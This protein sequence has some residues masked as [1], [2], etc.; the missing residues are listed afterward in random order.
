MCVYACVTSSSSEV[1][2]FPIGDMLAIWV[3]VA[4]RETE[5]DD[6]DAVFRGVA[7]SDQEVIRFNVAMNDSL[8][9]HLLNTLNLFE[10]INWK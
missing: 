3:P 10:T 7:P 1:F 9:V 6:E 2:T 5:I 4:F 8:F